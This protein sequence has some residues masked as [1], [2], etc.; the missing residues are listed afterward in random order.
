MT[1]LFL[2]KFPGPL[3]NIALALNLDP[4]FAKRPTETVI[5]GGNVYGIGNIDAKHTAEF[6]FGADPEAAYVV[7]ERMR[8]PLT[9]VPWEATC[10]ENDDMLGFVDEVAVAY[11]LS[12][13]KIVKKHRMLRAS[14][15]LSG[16]YT[17]HIF[18]LQ[19]LLWNMV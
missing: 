14:V 4:K 19:S 7:L 3:T 13:D 15:E 9:I 11:A 6:N 8:C 16:E 17:R 5:M 12:G 1:A 10:F 2:R 18:I